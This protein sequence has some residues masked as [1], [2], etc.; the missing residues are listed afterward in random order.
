VV[1]VEKE[2]LRARCTRFLSHHPQARKAPRQ[3]FRE[4]AERVDA[5]EVPDMYGEGPL[6]ADFER[7]MAT[8]LGKP[9]AVFMPSGTMAQQIAL[10]I[11]SERRRTRNV[12]FHPRSHLE[13]HEHK[14]YQELHGLSGVLVGNA[15]RLLTRKDL[16][17]VALPVA[18]LLLELP[19]REIGGRL[20][21]WEELSG[22]RAW[23]DE[24]G[25]ALHLDGARLWESQPFYD[26]PHAEI[27]ALFDSVYVS[28]YKGL[29]GVAG[30]V[31]AGPADFCAEARIWQRRHGGNL[32]HLFPYVISA[33]AALA[34]RLHKMSAYRDRAVAIARALVA[35]GLEVVPDPPQTNMMHVF[36]RGDARRLEAAAMTIAREEGLWL[37][38]SLMPTPLPT[39]HKVE[40]N[41]GD[42]TMELSV[43]EIAARLVSLG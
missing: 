40:L 8:L 28:F 16:D 35:A 2:A 21:S 7:E 5:G 42:A 12:A 24:R 30:A 20:P 4:L 38:A 15:D 31:L 23:A 29:G 13:L 17:A 3:F 18:A 9:A 1:D 32:I 10:R 11:W 14:A 36:L 34:E 41:V 27:G 39:L 26:R 22:I 25:A 33:R 19:Q 6:I 37:F 43:D